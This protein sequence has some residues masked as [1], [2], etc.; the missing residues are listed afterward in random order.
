[1]GELVKL[2]AQYSTDYANILVWHNLTMLLFSY[3]AD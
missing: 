3:E 1:M 2:Q